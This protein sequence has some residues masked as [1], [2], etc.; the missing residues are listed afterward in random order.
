MEQ[1]SPKLDKKSSSSYSP[2]SGDYDGLK[3]NLIPSSNENMEHDEHAED[4]LEALVDDLELLEYQRSRST[5]KIE[6]DEFGDDD[7]KSQAF[8]ERQEKQK[9]EMFT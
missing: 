5:P 7:E 2:K 9:Q 4:D 8:R 6:I 1:Y 3:L